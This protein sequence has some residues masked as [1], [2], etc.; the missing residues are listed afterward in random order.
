MGVQLKVK[1]FVQYD[2][3][4]R[5]QSPEKVK[6]LCDFL[7]YEGVLDPSLNHQIKYHEVALAMRSRPASPD[8][9]GSGGEGQGGVLKLGKEGPRGRWRRGIS[10]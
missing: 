4:V 10:Q 3:P 2:I 5:I 9:F 6:V 1:S 8:Q 7:L